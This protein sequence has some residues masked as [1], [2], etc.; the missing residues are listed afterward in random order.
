VIAAALLKRSTHLS[1]GRQEAIMRKAVAD[2]WRRLPQEI[3]YGREVRAFL[4]Q[5]GKFARDIT[6]QPNAPYVP[7]VTGIAIT[8][9]DRDLLRDSEAVRQ[10]P[11]LRSLARV[12]AACISAN[13][14]EPIIDY[15]VKNKEVMVLYLN[16]MLCIQYGLPLGYGGFREQS[17]SKLVGW[18]EPMSL[19]CGSQGL[20]L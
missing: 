6:Y 2:R 19:N 11:P 9:R 12:L 18:L 17:L 14:F 4:D 3:R 5:T 20:L 10:N 15:R 7:G 13:L 16:R 1:P 8:M